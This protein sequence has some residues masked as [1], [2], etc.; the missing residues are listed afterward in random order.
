MSPTHRQGMNRKKAN[1]LV[2]VLL[3]AVVASVIVA[4]MMNL[5]L[6]RST[7]I[8]RDD[9][10]AAG[11][12]RTS[13]SLGAIVSAWSEAGGVNCSAVD[14]YTLSGGTPGGCDCTYTATDGSGTTVC[15][16][17]GCSPAVSTN[18]CELRIVGAPQP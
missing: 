7:A 12:A 6:M 13:G 18:P 3:A 15:A 14:G 17:S 9:D 8:K 5:T 4:G 16:G 2:Q 1:A 11:A 10:R